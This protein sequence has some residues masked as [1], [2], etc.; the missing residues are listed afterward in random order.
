MS[1]NNKKK[2]DGKE[3]WELY[4][5]WG[6]ASSYR[7]LRDW[8]RANKGYG[9]QMGPFWAMWKYAFLNVEEAYPAYQKWYADVVA[10]IGDKNM[11]P[12]S[13]ILGYLEDIK[14]HA[15]NRP[16]ISNLRTYVAFCKAYGLVE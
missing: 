12:N 16:N 8:H 11:N 10:S 14:K 6:G 2:Y 1:V 15:K 9:S 5:S 3:C 13:T 7:K 4:M